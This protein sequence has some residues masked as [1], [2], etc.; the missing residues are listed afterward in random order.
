M[1]TQDLTKERIIELARARFFKEGFAR[2]TIEELSKGLAISKKT[3]YKF[4]D[5]KQD[6]VGQVLL[7]K[8]SEVRGKVARVIDGNSDFI[9][10]LDEVM[11]LIGMEVSEFRQP[12][13][14]DLQRHTPALF[15][16]L[17][18]FRRKAISE[19]LSR[20][21]ERGVAEGHVRGDVNTRVFLLS[22]LSTISEIIRPDTLAGE[23][24]SAREALQNILS[25]FLHGIL[26]EHAGKELERLQ[27]T[28]RS[29]P[30]QV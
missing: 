12:F 10:K 2:I 19:N 4:F 13:L 18:E 27:R 15:G 29:Q 17:M 11:T 21:L 1:T 6:L 23:S 5:T 25:I 24:F 3:V 28:Q 16:R 8:I 14:N 20:L 7:R 22:Y 30:A 9:A 26:T